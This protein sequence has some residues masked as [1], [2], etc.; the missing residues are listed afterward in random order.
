M[1]VW[2]RVSVLIVISK[3]SSL[4]DAKIVGTGPVILVPGEAEKSSEQI[5]Q[6]IV[7]VHVSSRFLNIY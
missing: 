1:G 6:Q 7:G 2:I 3:I 4:V 5:S